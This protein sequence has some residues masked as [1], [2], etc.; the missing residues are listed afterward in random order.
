MTTDNEKYLSALKNNNGKLDEIT[1]G[2][3]IGFTND[4]T[5]QIIHELI[6]EGKIEFQSFGICSYIIRQ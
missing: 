3:S 5:T 6:N 1:L 4:K 2:E